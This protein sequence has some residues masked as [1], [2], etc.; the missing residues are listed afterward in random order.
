L[1]AVALAAPGYAVAQPPVPASGAVL[2]EATENMSLKAL[3]NG[4]RKAVSE[5]LG[6]ALRGTP[7]CPE[8]L[9]AGVAPTATNCTLNA[10]GMDTISLATGLGTFNGSVTVVVQEVIDPNTGQFTPD[11]P[12]VVIAKGR[13]FGR[14][15]FS[16]AILHGVPLGSV[17]GHLSLDGFSRKLPFTGVFRLPFTIPGLGDVYLVDP[18]KFGVP[19]TFGVA[20]VLVN[21]TALGYPT[22]RFEI[23]F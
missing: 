7:L 23:T 8:A 3:A 11:S 19:P 12:E 10:T 5:L 6:I 22:V 21:E 13:F 20:P 18:A 2:Y 1:F 14:M 4:R 16:P 15:D 17:V 9:V